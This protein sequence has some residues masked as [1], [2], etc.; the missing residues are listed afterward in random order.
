MANVWQGVPPLGRSPDAAAFAARSRRRRNKLTVLAAL[1]V[2][3]MGAVSYAGVRLWDNFT[4]SLGKSLDFSLRDLDQRLLQEK[5][6]GAAA[7]AAAT[8]A[9]SQP[10]GSLTVATLNA[11]L[12]KYHWVDGATNVPTSSNGTI[13][14]VTL[15]GTHIETVI[16][17]DPGWCD[18]GLTITSNADPLI[19]QDQLLGP[20]T[21]YQDLYVPQPLQCATDQA[22][23]SKWASWPNGVPW[24]VRP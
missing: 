5:S 10:P 1:G 19:A 22:P 6:G 15:S 2:V 21:Y 16:Q 7:N 8:V 23:T 24:A 18:F 12:P 9:V 3:V 17:T 13:V 4:Q 20:G 11:A 14:G